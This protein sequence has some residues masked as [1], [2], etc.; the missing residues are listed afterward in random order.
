MIGTGGTN[1]T[2][3]A[4]NAETGSLSLDRLMTKVAVHYWF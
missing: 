2:T 4:T 3:V 1:G